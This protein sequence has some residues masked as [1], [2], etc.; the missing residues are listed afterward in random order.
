MI[1]K[2]KDMIINYVYIISNQ[3][4]RL[5]EL[6]SANRSY[7]EG[8]HL[9]GKRLGFRL[10]LGRAYI[11]FLMLVN[12]L[13]FLPAAIGHKVFQHL[14]CHLSIFLVMLVTGVIFATFGLFRDWLTDLVALRRIQMMW[15]LHFP[16]FE[17]EEYNGEINEIYIKSVEEDIK[18]QDLEKY[19]LDNLSN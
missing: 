7:N 18:K 10:R 9:D 19:I 4:V 2:I 5:Y 14:D 6:L 15:A 17:Y 3:P 16:H 11:V 8:L 12:V 1:Q 13:L